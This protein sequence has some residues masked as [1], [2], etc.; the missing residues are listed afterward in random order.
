LRV[1]SRGDVR[2][3]VAQFLANLWQGP[4]HGRPR[5]SRAVVAVARAGLITGLVTDRALARVALTA[6]PVPSTRTT[7]AV[8]TTRE[9]PAALGQ[10][11]AKL[12][13][14]PVPVSD[15]DRAKAFTSRRSGSTS[16]STTR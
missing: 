9:R 10:G 6:T 8:T 13:L 2:L 14:V 15:V 3:R 12:E 16:I 4:P 5:Q 1:R 7:D 11:D